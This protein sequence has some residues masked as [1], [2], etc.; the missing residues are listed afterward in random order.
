[1]W[2]FFW[3]VVCLNYVTALGDVWIKGERQ[4]LYEIF[5]IFLNFYLFT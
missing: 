3:G 1:M 2:A 4:S 5:V